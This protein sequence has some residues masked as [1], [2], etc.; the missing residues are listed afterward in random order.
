MLY[1]SSMN[2][3]GALKIPITHFYVNVYM[4][5]LVCFLVEAGRHLQHGTSLIQC[6]S[7][8]L[9]LSLEL[10]WELL[11]LH[12]SVVTT[13]QKPLAHCYDAADVH[14]HILH[15][16]TKHTHTTEF[17]PGF[18]CC[19]SHCFRGFLSHPFYWFYSFDLVWV[20]SLWAKYRLYPR[21]TN[22]IQTV[23][24]FDILS[25]LLESTWNL[26]NLHSLNHNRV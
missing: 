9:P 24:Y 23:T 16:N 22:Q 19:C 2:I 4:H 26:H 15:R 7:E 14:I 25:E 11:D 1:V 5:Y 18:F 8:G 6:R 13:L 17:Q 21:Q 10:R 20:F 12:C 3:N